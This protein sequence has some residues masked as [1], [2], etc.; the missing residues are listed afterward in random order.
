[1]KSTL[2]PEFWVSKSRLEALMDGVF[3]I[4][5]TLMVLEIKIPELS[6]RGSME[7]FATAMRHNLP[8]II[9]FLLSLGMLGMFWYRHHRQYH[10]IAR[11]TPGLLAINLAFLGAVAF[12]PFSA[13]VLGKYPINFGVYFIYLPNILMIVSLLSAQWIHA[14]YFDLLS[15]DITPAASRLI[16]IEN[17]LG[18]TVVALVTIFY[19]GM[20]LAIHHYH[21]GRASLGYVVWIAL[22]MIIGV[23]M[24]RRRLRLA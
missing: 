18:M 21:M 11:I 23:K 10:F 13:G 20:I 3:A 1:M 15:P 2:L 9:A 17:S 14:R 6:D 16:H 8:G 22:P 19:L 24:L 4:A 12:F 5:M 7:E